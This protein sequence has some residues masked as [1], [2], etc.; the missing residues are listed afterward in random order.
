M[1]SNEFYDEFNKKIENMNLEQLKDII[2]NIIR[3][4]PESK[5]EEILNMFNNTKNEIDDAQIKNKIQEYKDKFRQIDNGNLCFHATGYEDD[6]YYY[7]PWGGDW[8]WEYSDED[9][10]GNI[11]NEAAL[12]AVDLTNKK[13]YEYAKELLDIILYT[14]YQA[15]DDD[16]GDTF[17][18]SLTESKENNL[19]DINI[20]FL[21]L[22]AIYVTYQSSNN[23][24]RAEKIY[25][26]FKN[27][28]FESLSIEDSF[29]LGTEVLK[30]TENF[31]NQWI[32]L[33]LNKSG[34]IEYRLLKEAFEYNNYA[35]YQKYIEKIAEKQPKIYI[36]LFNYLAKK[37]QIDEIINI[38]NTALSILDKKL[39]IRNDIALYLAKYDEQNKEKY[40]LESFKANTNIP[41]LLRIIN[42]GYYETN[43]N[44]IENMIVIND[45]KKSYYATRRSEINKINKID[46]YYLKFFMGDFAEFFD[47]CLNQK[48]SLGWSGSFIQYA[49]NLWL[50]YF[51]NF[52]DS[53]VYKGILLQTFEEL[54]F[55]DNVSFLDED[56]SIIFEKWKKQFKIDNK[57]KYINWLKEIINKRVDAII[58][59]NHRK[60]YFKAAILVVAL[61]EV[62]ESNN[63]QSKESFVEQYHNKYSRRVAFRNEL[64]EY[65]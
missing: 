18:I 56:Y 17:D 2:N 9:K 49:V 39:T 15:I 63:I 4:I 23:S 52:S 26:Y 35:N 25:E 45:E 6:D 55:K 13:E 19:I 8:I 11:I 14:N 46:Y 33:L 41:N 40:I 12:F 27:E 36:D 16:G 30:D 54:D 22:Y 10:V 32:S 53:K 29:K 64:K 28:N 42:N 7:S 31:W 58:S 3:K 38:G 43:K 47:E 1:R 57:E 51:N 65:I 59:N 20:D 21:C 62:L 24:S 50:L 60:S 34:R 61:A 48:S 37:N 44:E 5:Y